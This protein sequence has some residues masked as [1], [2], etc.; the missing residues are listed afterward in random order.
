M[1]K[2]ILS[3]VFA[4]AL[5]VGVLVCLRLG[6]SLGR[7]RLAALGVSAQSGLGA[8]EGAVFGLMG[9]LIAFTFTGAAT[10]FDARR[11]LIT[12][13]VNAIGTAWLRLDLLEDKTR[14]EIRELFRSYVDAELEFS[15]RMGE[16]SAAQ[17]ALSQSLELQEQIWRR[18]VQVAK[19]ERS[20]PW[21]TALLAPINE[22][23]DLANNRALATRQHP[24]L[25][26]YV[27]LG[28]MV[29]ASA[30]LAGFGMAGARKQ[31]PLHLLSF[32]TIMSL[33]VYLILDLEFPRLGLV[34]IDSFD[35][36]LI[37]LRASM[38]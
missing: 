29:L 23:F 26:V 24:P 9:L 8:V 2:I 7:Q 12:Q 20:Q 1:T 28:A 17:A 21:A 37:E 32:A 5:F 34:R 6:W 16:P 10:R 3:A 36:A 25:A 27:L 35:R 22:M 31:S 14:D 33:A 13:Q 4:G 15:R 30:L 38:N 19:T 11:A 18:A